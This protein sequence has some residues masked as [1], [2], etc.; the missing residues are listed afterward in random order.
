MTAE[1]IRTICRNEENIRKG[2]L[3]TIP[4]HLAAANEAVAVYFRGRYMAVFPQED[5]T[6]AYH[7]K[8]GRKYF[9]RIRTVII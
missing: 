6:Q 1:E 2:I 4:K 5:V 8:D 7:V 9:S 3:Q